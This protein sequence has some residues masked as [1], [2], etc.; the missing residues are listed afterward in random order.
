MFR[1][2]YALLQLLVVFGISASFITVAPPPLL[3]AE[4][5]SPD[6]TPVPVVTDNVEEWAVGPG[7]LYWANNCFADEFNP[8]AELRRKPAAVGHR[9]VGGVDQR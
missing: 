8:F 2:P 3:Y 9:T 1:S 6:D 4:T 5:A 7:L